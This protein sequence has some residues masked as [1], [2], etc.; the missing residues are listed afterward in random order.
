MAGPKVM[1]LFKSLT[2]LCKLWLTRS[3]YHFKVTDKGHRDIMTRV[4]FTM[5]QN[6]LRGWFPAMANNSA[7]EMNI[8]LQQPGSTE[9][10]SPCPHERKKNH[11]L[12]CQY[13]LYYLANGKKGAG[14][15]T[16]SIDQS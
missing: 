7:D 11:S 6:N 2:S 14:L 8:P 5:N 1:S 16:Q 10:E 9:N 12:R 13:N 3:N 4:A 15:I